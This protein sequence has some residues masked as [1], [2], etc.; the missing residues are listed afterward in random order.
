MN[1]VLG[2]AVM[3]VAARGPDEDHP[4]GHQKF[5]TLGALAIVMFLSVSGFEIVK[6]AIQRLAA[7]PT[8]LTINALQLALLVGTLGVNA[9]VAWYES[10][11]GHEL[12]SDILLADAAH[13]RADVFV[14]IGVLV[15]VIAAKVGLGWADPVVAL[16]VAGMIV[17]LA[18]G[19]I[20]RSIPVLVDKQ[21]VPSE[22]IQTVAE[23]V[24]GVARAYDIRSRGGDVQ[25]F[26]ELTVAVDGTATVADAHEIADAVE[27]A[28]RDGLALHEVVVHVEPC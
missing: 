14:T 19:I 8:P 12:H 20:V 4:Y 7:G 6:G 18:Y 25:R 28:V 9:V 5:E 2:L 16:G 26:A 22:S 24:N 10:R 15:G 1:N 21:A 3:A 11:R 23:S 13:T 27:L 17:W